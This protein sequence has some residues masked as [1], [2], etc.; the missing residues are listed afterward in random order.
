MTTNVY[1]GPARTVAT[2]SRWSWPVILGRWFVYLD[3]TGFDKI[4]VLKDLVVMYAGNGQ[5]VQAWRDYF[6]AEPRDL[7]KQP[8][9][10]KEVCVCVVDAETGA[11]VNSAGGD[12]QVFEDSHFGGTGGEY[13]RDCW[14]TNRDA[15]RAVETAKMKD[16]SS[17]GDVKYLDVVNKR[18]NLMLVHPTNLVTI[19][20]V[21]QALHKRGV[22][23]DLRKNVTVGGEAVP[24]EKAAAAHAELAEFGQQVAAGEI[25]PSAP[26][27]GMDREWTTAEKQGLND[28]LRKYGWK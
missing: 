6:A 19:Q 18:G 28:A 11:F 2:D 27:A 7:S 22:V 10:T 1:D 13:A 16:R 4:Q 25:S 20:M 17:G 12:Y 9:A 3:D 26:F 21:N 14:A 24:F 5:L 15:I 23:M 8:A